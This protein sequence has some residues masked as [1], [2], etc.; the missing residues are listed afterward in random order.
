MSCGHVGRAL[1]IALAMMFLLTASAH[2]GRRRA[3]L[4]R[5]VPAAFPNP[6]LMV[7]VTGLAEIAGAVGLLLPGTARWAAVGLAA[8][9]TRSSR[10]TSGRREGLW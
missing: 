10:R 6:E 7:T 8:L 3:D 2:W 4:V 1:R 9:L 5:M